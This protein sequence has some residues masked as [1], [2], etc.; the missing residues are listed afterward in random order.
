MKDIHNTNSLKNKL[1]KNL[2]KLYIVIHQKISINIYLRH[3]VYIKY[4]GILC[5]LEKLFYIR[6]FF[7]VKNIFIFR[8]KFVITRINK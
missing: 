2:K 1:L 7:L 8:T 6:S 4:N 5:Y 3:I